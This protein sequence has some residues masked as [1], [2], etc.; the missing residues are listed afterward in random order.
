MCC[1][2]SPAPTMFLSFLMIIYQSLIYEV[3]WKLKYRTSLV[4]GSQLSS[5]PENEN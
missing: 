5:S 4:N 1:T 3:S 2:L